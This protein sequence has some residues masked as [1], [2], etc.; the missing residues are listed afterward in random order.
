M[1]FRGREENRCL[2]S[3]KHLLSVGVSEVFQ[4]LRIL[5]HRAGNH[6]VFPVKK[7]GGSRR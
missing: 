6:R 5:R 4:D 3:V 7:G 1:R 2:C